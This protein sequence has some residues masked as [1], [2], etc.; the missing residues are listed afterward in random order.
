MKFTPVSGAVAVAED[1][2]SGQRWA[3]AVVGVDEDGR[4]LL[5]DE[6]DGRLMT[7][8]EYE[9]DSNASVFI[10][11]GLTPSEIPER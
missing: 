11:S 3:L 6:S 9:E 2:N 10:R 7:V 5:L 4:A 8:Q 1:N